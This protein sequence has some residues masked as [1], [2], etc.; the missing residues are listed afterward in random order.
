MHLGGRAFEHGRP[1]L[2][3]TGYADTA[4][5]QEATRSHFR[6]A[7]RTVLSLLKEEVHQPVIFWK[8]Q[9]RSLLVIFLHVISG[10]D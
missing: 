2:D 10:I 1:G 4:V 9:V 5:A 7:K 6:G 3:Q 8:H